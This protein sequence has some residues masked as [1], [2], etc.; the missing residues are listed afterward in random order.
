[1]YANIEILKYRLDN[2]SGP[3]VDFVLNNISPKPKSWLDIGCGTGEIL[4]SAQDRG[5]HVI[6]VETNKMQRD[7]ARDHFN[8]D[9]L[10]E[11]ITP[12]NIGKV[13]TTFDVISLFSV[14]EHVLNP[15][16]LIKEISAIQNQHST[17]VVEVPHYPSISSLTQSVFPEYVNRMMH[18]PFHLFLFS[19][20]GMEVLLGRY[21]YEITNCWFFGQDWFEFITTMLLVIPKLENTDLAKTMISLIDDFQKIIDVNGYSDEM[22]LLARKIR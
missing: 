11:F 10:D 3:K 8:I 16:A 4:K 20:K 6:G 18:P 9:V 1:L 14:L 7:F 19:L 2:I 17:L 15:D 12:Q 22:L 21:G 5:L 13:G